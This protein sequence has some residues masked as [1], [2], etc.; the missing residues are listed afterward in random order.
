MGGMIE[1]IFH[2][3]QDL[4]KYGKPV[5]ITENGLADR[6]DKY[7]PWFTRIVENVYKYTQLGV[8]VRIFLLVDA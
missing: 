4:R 8:D 2:C 3:L 5:Y 1:A 6:E 7:R